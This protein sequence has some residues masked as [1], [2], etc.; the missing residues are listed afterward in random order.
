MQM[1]IYIRVRITVQMLQYLKGEHLSEAHA[2]LRCNRARE[3]PQG[4]ALRCKDF[5]PDY[6]RDLL[7]I[8]LE[9]RG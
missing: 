7:S 9:P 6:P 5:T 4:L 2:R 8:V 3:A 1:K